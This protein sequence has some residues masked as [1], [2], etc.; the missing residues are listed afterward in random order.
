MNFKIVTKGKSLDKLQ[1]SGICEIK[2]N[3]NLTVQLE[4]RLEIAFYIIST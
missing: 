4:A 2:A 3:M 1:C